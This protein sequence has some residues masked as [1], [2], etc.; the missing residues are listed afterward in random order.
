MKTMKNFLYIMKPTCHWG[1]IYLFNGFISY[2]F[3]EVYTCE[4]E[5]KICS[6]ISFKC[7]SVW[8]AKSKNI[9][10]PVASSPMLI[11]DP[12]CFPFLVKYSLK[13]LLWGN[14]C[15]KFQLLTFLK[16]AF[17][18]LLQIQ[19]VCLKSVTWPQIY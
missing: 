1:W 17:P 4:Q 14:D 2:C 19:T 6:L 18:L 5:C 11:K 3:T 9:C 7:K 12:F 10:L 8:S 15:R 13:W 16:P